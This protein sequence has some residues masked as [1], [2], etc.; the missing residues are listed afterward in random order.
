M[1]DFIVRKLVSLKNITRDALNDTFATRTYVENKFEFQRL[2]LIF[3]L[4]ANM[5][6]EIYKS[7]IKRRDKIDEMNQ[8]TVK[9]YDK[10]P[11][12]IPGLYRRKDPDI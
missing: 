10:S 12:L 7:R 6:S 9:Q 4:I 5:L 1:L 3:N 8:K 2:V 11:N